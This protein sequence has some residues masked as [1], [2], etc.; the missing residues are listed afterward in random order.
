MPEGSTNPTLDFEGPLHEAGILHIAGL[1]EAGRG[2]LAG[3][4]TAAAVMLP[5]D[6]PSALVRL[7]GVRDSKLLSPEQRE[8]ALGV[9]QEVARCWATG[10]ASP[11][12]VD[13]LGLLPATRLAMLRALAD[14]SVPPEHLMI[15][16]LILPD[17]ERPQ[18]ALVKGDRR[19]LTIAAASVV[20]KVLRDRE[21]VELDK[22][23]PG[24]GWASNKG[25]GTQQ[26]RSALE[27]RGA[28]PVHR[29]S[30]APVAAALT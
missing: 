16:H 6:D 22:R 27:Q 7:A 1:D 19:S 12:E 29:R 23:Y 28:S 24:Y 11:K 9:I 26:H 4:V 10:S 8:Q 14:L 15:D 21:M 30:Y 5:L 2:A 25:Y 18:T 13:S 17:D 20:A 3:P